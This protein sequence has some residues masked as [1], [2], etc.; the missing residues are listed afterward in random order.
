MSEICNESI[1]LSCLFLFPSFD[2][3][4]W[5]FFNKLLRIWVF[6][7]IYLFHGLCV[8]T[9]MLSFTCHLLFSV[10]SHQDLFPH[11]QLY[12]IPYHHFHNKLGSLIDQTPVQCSFQAILLKPLSNVSEISFSFLWPRSLLLPMAEISFSYLWHRV[13]RLGDHP[14]CY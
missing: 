3:F 9:I 8:S 5:C 12:S 10:P 11:P 13:P 6:L 7:L 14:R 4:Y 1:F 2:F